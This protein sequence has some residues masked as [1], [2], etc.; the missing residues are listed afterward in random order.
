MTNKLL[1]RV[2]EKA[3]A[4]GRLCPKCGWIITVKNWDKGY[5][6]CGGCWDAAQGVNV[7]GGHW[8][9]GQEPRDMTGDMA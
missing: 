8:Q 5:R 9:D 1:A 2:Y 6:V 7:K 4:A 3:K